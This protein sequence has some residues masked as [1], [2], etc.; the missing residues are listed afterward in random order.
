MFSLFIFHPLVHSFS[1]PIP[2]CFSK[3]LFISLPLIFSF[4]LSLSFSLS[5][6]PILPLLR[7]LFP[8]CPHIPFLQSLFFSSSY[9]PVPHAL[10]L[11]SFFF[12][13]CILL[14]FSLS[15]CIAKICFSS[16]LHKSPFFPLAAFLSY[17]LFLPLSLSLSRSF[18]FSTIFI[19]LTF[20]FPC[21][22]SSSIFTYPFISPSSHCFSLSHSFYLS[23]SISL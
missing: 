23:R 17:F 19:N 9:F 11:F 1:F 2:Y 7:D 14:S 4:L 20:C 15:N 8:F 6:F 10:L 16:F 21:L 3:P 13:L 12:S 18:Y 22:M 5:L